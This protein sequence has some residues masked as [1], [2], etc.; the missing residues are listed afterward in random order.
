MSF[1]SAKGKTYT[2][3]V[4][5]EDKV[6]IGDV[7]VVEVS[8]ILKLV[9]VVEVHSTPKIDASAQYAFKWIVQKLNYERY[10]KQIEAESK[11]QDMLFEIERA[12]QRTDFQN[13]FLKS[14][15]GNEAATSLFKEALALINPNDKAITNGN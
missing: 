14:I 1:H 10:V 6:S 12:K 7:C 3:K 5:L 11:V 2:Y 8:G 15:E 4:L 9:Q 13:D